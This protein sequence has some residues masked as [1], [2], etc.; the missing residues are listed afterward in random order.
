MNGQVVEHQGWVGDDGGFRAP[1][2]RAQSSEQFLDVER[3]HEAVVGAGIEVRDAHGRVVEF[4]HDDDRGVRAGAEVR[5]RSGC[6]RLGFD[7]DDG[8][9]PI[10]ADRAACLF[11]V[12][13]GAHAEVVVSHCAGRHAAR[14][15]TRHRRRG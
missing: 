6:R 9:Q 3:M 4:R 8:L 5:N 14:D 7:E 11:G 13:D 1:N 10:A 12:G 2:P 15:A